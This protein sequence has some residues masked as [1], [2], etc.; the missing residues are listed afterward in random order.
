MSKNKKYTLITSLTIFMVALIIFGYLFINRS[1]T[2]ETNNNS[3]TDSSPVLTPA[4][5]EEKQQ[6][7]D[8]KKNNDSQDS[9]RS[10]NTTSSNNIKPL[11]SVLENDGQQITVAGYIPE[12]FEKDGLC[13]VS[14][15]NGETISRQVQATPE[16]RATYCP[17]ITI[18]ISGFKNKGIWKV[19]IDYKSLTSLGTSESKDIEIK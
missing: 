1:T 12:L 18:P 5:D 2:K 15:T 14:L 7:E 13:T 10:T 6:A 11:I 8:N 16:G 19:N 9:T 4:T 3:A 17:T